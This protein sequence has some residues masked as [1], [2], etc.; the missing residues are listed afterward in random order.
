[1]IVLSAIFLGRVWCIMCPVEMVTSFFSKTGLKMKRPR[2]V[3][4]GWIIT[5]F[6]LLILVVGVTLLQVDMNPKY[7]SYYLLAIMGTAILSGMVF[8][9]N[10][11]CRYICPVGYLLG[12]FSKLA[13]WGWR[14]KDTATCD[15]CRDKS[16]ISKKY[17]YRLTQKSCGV[18]L[19]PARIDNNTHC[20]LCGGCRQT[21][22]TH[23]PD[24]NPMR[25]NPGL[26]KTGFAQDL[27]QIQPLHLAEWAFLFVLTGSMIFEMTHF[28]ITSGLSASFISASLHLSEGWI[29]DIVEVAY[30]HFLLPVILWVVPYL[31]LNARMQI[32]VNE[33]QKNISLIS[34]P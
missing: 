18:D 14:V 6:Y 16:C 9:K 30:L 26:V 13:V 29:K 15:S 22:K 34:F 4:S 3:L 8:E 1:M 12:I 32:S 17:I 19:I 25:P 33:Y 10:T 23:N 7:T 31:L 27:M 11:F 2:W 21:C 24:N 5:L 28:Q 20:L